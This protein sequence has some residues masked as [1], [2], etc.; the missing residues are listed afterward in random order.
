MAIAFPFQLM[1]KK[2]TGGG[3]GGTGPLLDGLSTSAVFAHSTRKLRSVYAGAA[4]QVKRSSD[5]ATQDIGFDGNGDLDVAALATFIGANTGTISIWYDQT[6]NGN[7][8]TTTVGQVR[9]SGTNNTIGANSRVAALWSTAM[10]SYASLGQNLTNN[11][12]FIMVG[13]LTSNSV[14]YALSASADGGLAM[15]SGDVTAG[16]MAFGKINV[17]SIAASA[18]G[19][20][21]ITSPQCL[22]W[23]FDNSN[24]NY[25]AY[26]DGTSV[27]SGTTGTRLNASPLRFG[28]YPTN[29]SAAP[30]RGYVGEMVMF[31]TSGSLNST[32]RAAIFSN[33]K[34]YWGTP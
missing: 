32:D 27:L 2:A 33:Q 23:S 5:N 12:S 34:A 20:V 17:A 16:D 13:K 31:D 4:F 6:G 24:G 1:K 28:A 22:M 9:T 10:G 11:R 19:V 18:G 30:W 8:M 21:G 15:S 25:A 29:L 26:V 3:G 7:N 14:S